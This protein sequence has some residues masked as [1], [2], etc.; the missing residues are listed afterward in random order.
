MLS[1]T[2]PSTAP[3]VHCPNDAEEYIH[4]SHPMTMLLPRATAMPEKPCLYDLL[5][6]LLLWYVNRKS[7]SYF[8]TAPV[9]KSNHRKQSPLL[10]ICC[11][12]PVNYL[13]A[14]S[15]YP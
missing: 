8:E 7:Q 9:Y 15:I 3:M 4:K 11:H 5:N 2:W 13:L 6:N 10:H 1:D 14:C 12:S